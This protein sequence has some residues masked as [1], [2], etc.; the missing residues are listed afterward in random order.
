MQRAFKCTEVLS[1]YGHSFT[2]HRPNT[3][4]NTASSVILGASIENSTMAMAKKL[5]LMCPLRRREQKGSSCTV[6]RNRLARKEGKGMSLFDLPEMAR[7]IEPNSETAVIRTIIHSRLA[8][9]DPSKTRRSSMLL[10]CQTACIQSTH[11]NEMRNDYPV[12]L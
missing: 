9:G 3:S 7:L 1:V 11:S 5:S 8:G 10:R 2:A 12:V 4:I 6:C